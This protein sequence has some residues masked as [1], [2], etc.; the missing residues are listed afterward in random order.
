MELHSGGGFCT[1]WGV[2]GEANAGMAVP[3]TL[4]A[5]EVRC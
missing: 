3:A 1:A 4:G 5:G 2:A